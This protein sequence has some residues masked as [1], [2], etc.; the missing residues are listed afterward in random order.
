MSSILQS[1]N[2]PPAHGIFVPIDHQRSV[3]RALLGSTPMRSSDADY[4]ADLL[5]TNELRCI[6]SH[7]SGMLSHYLESFS[8]GLVNPEPEVSVIADYGATAVVDGDGGMGYFACRVA[9]QQLL[10]KT[11]ALGMGAATTRNHFHIGSAGIWTR[12]AVEQGFI[13]MAMSDHRRQIDPQQMVM[14]V[15]VS[16]PMS[17][18]FPAGDQPPFILDMGGHMMAQRKDLMEE[19]PNGFFKALGISAATQ[20]FAS[21]LAG[22]QKPEP[23]STKWTSNQGAFLCAWDVSCFVGA[24]EFRA[25]MDRF[26]GKV[27]EMQPFPGLDRAELPGGMEWQ[28][29]RESREHGAIMLGD[30][31][32]KQVE[33][34]A[35]GV[36]VDCGYEAFEETRF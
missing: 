34:L 14:G 11:R 28:W 7:G 31:H 15:I 23:V 2:Y 17:I 10:E 32:R 19:M 5:V 30:Q 36:G 33:E 25:D 8:E 13:G 9:M 21:V 1:R 26:V 27:R 4:L 22:I 35:V 20:T 3:I 29:E 6:Y 24:D 18:G 12:M 16:S